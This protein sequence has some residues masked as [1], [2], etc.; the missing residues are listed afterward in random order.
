MAEDY[1]RCSVSMQVLE[2]D[3]LFDFLCV[4]QEVTGNI[5]FNKLEKSRKE[6]SWF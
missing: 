4:S 1:C 5:Y 6:E 2:K 3:K